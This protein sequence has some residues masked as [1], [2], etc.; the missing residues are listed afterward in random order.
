[1][2]VYDGQD[3]LLDEVSGSFPDQ[4][5]FLRQKVVDSEKIYPT[6]FVHKKTSSAL[7]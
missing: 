3:L 2:P 7:I 1:V 5:F 6:K 4:L